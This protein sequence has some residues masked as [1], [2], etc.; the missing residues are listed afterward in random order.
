MAPQLIIIDEPELGL[1]PF[2]VELFASMVREASHHAQIIIA[3]QSE[4]LLRQFEPEDI[5]VVERE[6]GE[7]KFKRLNSEELSE[8]L[9][10]YSIDELWEKNIL[11]GR[12]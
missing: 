5:I 12:P 2:A 8:W 3:T 10:E 7:S 9:E 6:D 4:T 1:H 11:G